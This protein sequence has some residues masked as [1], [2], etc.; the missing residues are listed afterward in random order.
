M[1]IRQR[2]VDVDRSSESEGVIYQT[3]CIYTNSMIGRRLAREELVARTE[4]WHKCM[5]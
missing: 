1:I 2:N 5:A 3:I 4:E